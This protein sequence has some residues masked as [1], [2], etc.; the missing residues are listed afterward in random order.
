MTQT[1]E[2]GTSTP[3]LGTV[4]PELGTTTRHQ[5]GTM[6][7]VLEE[8][9]EN[10]MGLPLLFT[11]GEKTLFILS[12][13]LNVCGDTKQQHIEIQIDFQNFFLL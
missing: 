6:W 10:S 7:V 12:L 4:T 5:P 1:L 8:D 9:D 11:A 13:L 3:E 2:L